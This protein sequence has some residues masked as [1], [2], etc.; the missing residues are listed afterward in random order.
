MRDSYRE[1]REPACLH[2]RQK[3][4]KPPRPA[5][6]IRDGERLLKNGAIFLSRTKNSSEDRQLKIRRIRCSSQ[7]ENVTLEL[8]GETSPLYPIIV[9][10]NTCSIFLSDG[11]RKCQDNMRCFKHIYF[12]A[13][14]EVRGGFKNKLHAQVFPPSELCSNNPSRAAAR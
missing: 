2:M 14:A 13:L 10:I 4:F 7:Y 12:L 11:E 3:C 1:E 6:A 5:H 8:T 9:I